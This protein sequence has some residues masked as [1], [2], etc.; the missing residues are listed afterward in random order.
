[1]A[2]AM[3]AP[4]IGDDDYKL[5]TAAVG[6]DHIA[7]GTDDTLPPIP[8][9]HDDEVYTLVWAQFAGPQGFLKHRVVVA[10]SKTEVTCGDRQVPDESESLSS[11]VSTLTGVYG[12]GGSPLGI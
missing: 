4:S 1:M 11:S 3:M 12:S 9:C 7:S 2:D 6:L 5:A 8:G 10:L